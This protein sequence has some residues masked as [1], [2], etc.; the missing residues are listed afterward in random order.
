MHKSSGSRVDQIREQKSIEA[1]FK[2]KVFTVTT[3]QMYKLT[4]HIAQG[5]AMSKK[6][7]RSGYTRLI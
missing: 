3:E 2:L 7:D 5:Y 1:L 4:D 6:R